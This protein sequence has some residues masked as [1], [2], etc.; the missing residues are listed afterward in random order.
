MRKKAVIALLLAA[1]LLLASCG[2]DRETDNSAQIEAY[3]AQ[4]AS[5]EEKIIK[6]NEEIAGKDSLI[7]ELSQD[8]KTVNE[9]ESRKKETESYYSELEKGISFNGGYQA[10]TQQGPFTGSYSIERGLQTLDKI[11]SVLGSFASLTSIVKDRGLIDE[12]ELNVIG[13]TD[14]NTQLV[15]FYNMPIRLK[16]QM[17]EMN[18]I[19]KSLDMRRVLALYELGRVDKREVES[20]FEAYKS[21]KEQYQKF[22]SSTYYRDSSLYPAPAYY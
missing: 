5:L 21:A 17:L 1:G 7:E 19:I 22:V 10:Y 12:E 14:D 9:Q 15:E 13:N 4:I 20:K 2:E 8:E 18:Y 16:G 6:L 11:S 3:K